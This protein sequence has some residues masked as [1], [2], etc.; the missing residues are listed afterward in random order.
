MATTVKP[1]RSYEPFGMVERESLTRWQDARLTLS[2][3][4]IVTRRE[5][6]D[7]FR[8]W[9][10]IVPIVVLT[11]LFP[12]LAQFVAQQFTGFVAEYGADIVAER[13]IPFLLMII[14]F[15]PISISLVIALETFV[16]EKERRSLEPLL[17]TPLTNTELYIGK[18]L[19]AMIPPLIASYGGMT[20]YLVALVFGSL[21]WR[22]EPALV[23]Q[24][25][26]ITTVQALVMVTGAV[27]VSSQTTSTRAANLL[28]SFIIIPMT[29]AIQGESAI[30][31]LAPDAESPR[32]IFA[33]WAIIVGMFIVVILLLRVGNSIFNREELLGRSID[34]IQLRSSLAKIWRYVRAVDEDGTPAR[35][36]WHWYTSGMAMSLRQLKTASLITIA[37]FIIAMLGGYYVGQL[38]QWH[39]PLPQDDSLTDTAELLNSRAYFTN[40]PLQSKAVL[41]IVWQNAR[42]LVGATL[43]AIFSFGVLPLV[44]TP[45]VYFLLGYIFSQVMLA[46]LDPTFLFAGILTHGII[47]IPVIIIAT[48]AALRLGAIVTRLPE[49]ETVGHA[50][51][52]TFGSTIKL[53]IGLIIPGLILSALIEA[54][55]TPRIV[56]SI[57]G[58]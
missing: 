11:F 9:R 12:A 56:I 3:A 49:G 2:N 38:P 55:I 21:Q 26:L 27:V 48:A 42:I 44:L 32:G 5:V 31:F 52:T 30:M 51:V 7:S 35:N 10:I 18:T 50:W 20:V 15:F 23:L 22:P 39:L 54:F 34:Q 41:F 36:V 1:V 4:L 16:G 28:A 17:S 33:L 37:V 25:I 40:I 45:V 14:G 58:S 13:T 8:D 46:G 43:L 53:W 6:R 47:E 19:A 29:L 57:L 24:I